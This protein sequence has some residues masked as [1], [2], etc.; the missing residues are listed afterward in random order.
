[1]TTQTNIGFE[2]RLLQNF[3]LVLDLYNKTT[4]GILQD[5][6]I[7]GYVGATGNPVGNVA[8]MENKGV[9]IELGYN[10][11]F[12]EFNLSANANV[13]Y[14]ENEVIYL[15]NDID[16]LSGGQTIQSSTYP[17][18]RTAVGQP[19]NSF[20]GF[21]T[22]GIFQNQQAIDNYT[23]SEGNPIQPDAVPGDF[24]WRDLDGDGSITEKDRNFLG[25]S[26]PKY[27]FGLTLNVNYKNFDMM[28]F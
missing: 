7:P 19:F 10:K 16:Y 11:T 20:Y 14:L 12:G 27:T 24:K 1:E 17:I 22:D 21:T 13:S 9:D 5:V 18:T 28:V 15:G 2:A 23:N 4:K 6:R 25:S 3:S 8:D 26:I